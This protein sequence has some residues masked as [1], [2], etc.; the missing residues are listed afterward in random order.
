M[1]TK[2]LAESLDEKLFS[3]KM[4]RKLYA[5][6]AFWIV[7]SP[8]VTILFQIFGLSFTILIQMMI[9]SMAFAITK[10]IELVFNYKKISLKNKTSIDFLIIALFIWFLVSTIVNNAFNL[11][12]IYGFCYFLLFILFL[13]LEKKYYRTIAIVFVSGMSFSSLL[14][15]IDIHN[16]FMPSYGVDEF[17]MSL[18]F[19]N[20]N[21]SAVVVI[22]AEIL[23]LWL[24]Y[25]SEK[26]WQK[27]L[28]FLGYIVMTIG[29]FVG[30]SYAPET[31]LFLCE[32]TIV[33]YLWIKN[34]KCPWLILSAFLATIFI[35]FAVWFVPVVRDVST[36]YVNFFYE[37][38]AVIDH[39]LGT[40]LLKN[41]SSFFNKIFGFGEMSSVA[42]ADGWGRGNLNAQAIDS[43]FSSAKSFIFGCGCG[44]IYDSVR[45][46]N[47]FLVVWM[48]FGTIGMLL[49]MSIIVMIFVRFIK[50]KKTD[51]KV[52]LFSTFVMVLFD[53]YF[54]CIE[55]FFFPFVVVFSSILYR[56]LF[57]E[58]LENTKNSGE[59]LSQ[60]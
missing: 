55:P 49:F 57:K 19:V 11:S 59:E 32:A 20:P 22:I 3:D 44:Y 36:A 41:V 24:I 10:V 39:N 54:C 45:V 26:K 48:E 51:C 13:S 60:N 58:K 25:S 52:F 12:F 2:K 5:F 18:Q 16:K 21:W 37:S 43:I 15:L 42:G 28:Y 7:L 8:I 6:Y 29:L 53:L 38:L 47:A 50:I 34:K 4:F 27:A 9:I 35:S 46:H 33:I 30:G 31:A 56:I 14:G 23:C 40:K 1:D 17:S